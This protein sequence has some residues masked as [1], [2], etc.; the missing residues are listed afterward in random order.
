MQDWWDGFLDDE[1]LQQGPRC[2][3]HGD[4]WW[5]NLLVDEDGENLLGVIDFGDVSIVDPAYDFVPL[6]QAGPA[7][8]EACAEA[9]QRL[10]G[11]LDAGFEYRRGL[12]RE[13]RSGSFYSLRSAIRE[14]DRGEIRDSLQ[15]LRNSRILRHP[16]S[17]SGK[18]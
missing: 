8:S 3:V 17:R 15:K 6:A 18:M 12:W 11:D 10:G 2:L 16:A 9:Y 13:L 14:D 4:L 5:D 7:F 1:A